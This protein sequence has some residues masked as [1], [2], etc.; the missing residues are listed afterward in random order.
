MR[1]LGQKR[2]V[3]E[4][5]CLADVDQHG[6]RALR[7]NG[8]PLRGAGDP[9]RSRRIESPSPPPGIT[10]ETASPANRSWSPVAP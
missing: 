2:E 9:P 5:P 6:P 7:R 10:R 3:G 1:R 8:R 4:V